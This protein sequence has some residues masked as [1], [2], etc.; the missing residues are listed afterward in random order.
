VQCLRFF[1]GDALPFPFS[2]KKFQ[3]LIEIVVSPNTDFL[4]KE[5]I[6]KNLFHWFF[7]EI[8]KLA[9]ARL[10]FGSFPRN[11]V[12]I[13]KRE[14]SLYPEFYEWFHFLSRNF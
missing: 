11:F 1:L 9:Q 12:Q 8:S 7:L 10:M 14:L 6:I 3:R 5:K 4:N 13:R 2:K